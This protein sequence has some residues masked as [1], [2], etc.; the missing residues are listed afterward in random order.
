MN[1]S[2]P[3]IPYC[4]LSQVTVIGAGNVGSTL[5]QRLI[6]RNLANVVL[7]DIVEGRPQGIA[8]D[9]MES[10]GCEGHHRTIVGTNDYQ[11]TRDSDIIVITAGLPRKPGMSR[12]DLMQVN[13]NIVI[14]TVTRALEYSPPSLC[15]CG[16]QPSGCD[17]LSGL[18]GQWLTVLSRDGHGRGF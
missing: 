17:D 2:T 7:I 3:A 12:D 9:L 16:D 11:D 18:E 10:R 8:L 4:H 13:G 1:A 5:A 15:H 6:E 14:E